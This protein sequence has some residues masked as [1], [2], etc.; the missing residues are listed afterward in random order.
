M[1]YLLYKKE[2]L[3]IATSIESANEGLDIR[4]I[5]LK[6]FSF[7]AKEESFNLK[8][9][10]L[11]FY[12]AVITFFRTKL[13]YV[14]ENGQIVHTSYVIPKCFKFPFLSTD[15]FEI[16]PCF[17]HLAYRGKGIYPKVLRFILTTGRD[18]SHFFMLVH[19]TNQSSI[20][21]IEK[22][23]FSKCGVCE[24]ASFS[25]YRKVRS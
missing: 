20:K 10:L 6:P 11:R 22:A 16:G 2:S 4:S 17:T 23:G 19:S 1:S 18:K 13:Y 24:K 7:F 8:I 21:G 15:D 5:R 9:F 14:V 3:R 12:F 25:V